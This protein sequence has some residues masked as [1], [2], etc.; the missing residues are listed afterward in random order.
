VTRKNKATYRLNAVKNNQPQGAWL[1]YYIVES[2]DED[3]PPVIAE[4]AAFTTAAAAKRY[5]AAKVGRS[6]LTWTDVNADGLTLT[7]AV[8]VAVPA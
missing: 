4:Y 8:E 1:A 2:N 3:T 6:R 7:A 5:L